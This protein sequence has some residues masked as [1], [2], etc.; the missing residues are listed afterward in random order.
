MVTQTWLLHHLISSL[1]RLNDIW[2]CSAV[3]VSTHQQKDSL[4]NNILFECLY[5]I[6]SHMNIF[7][8]YLKILKYYS[9]SHSTTTPTFNNST[10]LGHAPCW[11]WN[12]VTYPTM[13][14]LPIFTYMHIIK[15]GSFASN[16]H[17]A[18]FALPCGMCHSKLTT[19]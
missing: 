13:H 12:D 8:D 4:N 18:Y 6:S 3:D 2:E 11:I 17:G 7:Y 15:V 10:F 1:S 19:K 16:I 9:N 5:F 14:S